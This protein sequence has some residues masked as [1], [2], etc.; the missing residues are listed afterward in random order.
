MPRTTT[1]TTS[2][3]R[4]LLRGG[5]RVDP[6][7]SDASTRTT[8]PP[9]AMRP[10]DPSGDQLRPP[11]D[12]GEDPAARI[13]RGRPTGTPRWVRVLGIVIAIALIAL[14]VVLHLTGALGA[15]AHR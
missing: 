9:R 1:S 12:S 2:P 14:P 8:S 4:R 7:A 13:D 6:L 15:G 10:E 5:C 11:P 3:R